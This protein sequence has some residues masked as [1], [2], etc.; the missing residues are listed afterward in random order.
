MK[1]VARNQHQLDDIVSRIR[2]MVEAHAVTVD[3]RKWIPPRTGKQNRKVYAMLDDLAAF[4][5]DRNIKSWIKAMEFWPDVWVEHAGEGRMVPKS[6]ADLSRDEESE[7][8][9]HLYI[10]GGELPGFEW[11]E[12]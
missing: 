10:I 5:G 3:Y 8:I 2:T 12:T 11:S 9:E 6:E 4:T 1:F 7:V